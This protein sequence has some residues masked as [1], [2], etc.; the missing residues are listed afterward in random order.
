MIAAAGTRMTAAPGKVTKAVGR[1]YRP[2]RFACMSRRAATSVPHRSCGSDQSDLPTR[3]GPHHM[4]AAIPMTIRT[5]VA[6]SGNNLLASHGRGMDTVS[7][8]T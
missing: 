8:T 7:R 2:P 6:S 1:V 4:V 5:A 3:R